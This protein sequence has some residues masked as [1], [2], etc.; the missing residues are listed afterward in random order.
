MTFCTCKL[1]ASQRV[2]SLQIAARHGLQVRPD[3]DVQE[4][5]QRRHIDRKLLKTSP[6]LHTCVPAQ[7]AARYGLLVRPKADVD[8]TQRGV[9]FSFLLQLVERGVVDPQWTIQVSNTC[10]W[11]LSNRTA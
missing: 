7:V 1:S 2:A 5:C 10:V 8:V 3:V 11:G 6:N 4:H 9:S